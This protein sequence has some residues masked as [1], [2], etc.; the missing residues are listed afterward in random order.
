MVDVTIRGLDQATLKRLELRAMHRGA[1]LEQELLDILRRSAEERQAVT[2]SADR[3]AFAEEIR[4]RLPPAA[5]LLDSTSL[6][7][8]ARDSNYG[9]YY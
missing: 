4:R 2:D 6:I 9:R 1:T 3:L 5:G 7:R 8:M